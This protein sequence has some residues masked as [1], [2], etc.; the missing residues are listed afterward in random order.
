[1]VRRSMRDAIDIE[2]GVR[3]ERLTPQTL[4]QIDFLELVYEPGAQS[5]SELYRHP[6]AEMV[7]VLTGRLDIF[8]GFERTR[9]NPATAST[10]PR[11][12]RIGTSTRPTRSP[13]R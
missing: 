9:W 12:S 3:W 7:L 6:G 8:V 10:S 11:R 5:H 1:M 2:G 4:P 13:G